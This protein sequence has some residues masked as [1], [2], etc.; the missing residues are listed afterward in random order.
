MNTQEIA[1]L[2]ALN[3][4]T[5]EATAFASWNDFRAA[6]QAG[7]VPTMREKEIK[8]KGTNA[9]FHQECVNKLAQM[10]RAE[11]FKVFSNGKVS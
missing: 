8:R 2:A 3:A 6:M 5:K 1:K 7:Y 9:S 10:V 4:M 11:G